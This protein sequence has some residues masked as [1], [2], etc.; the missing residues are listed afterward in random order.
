M[1]SFWTVAASEYALFAAASYQYE[2]CT[3]SFS[4]DQSDL[5]ALAAEFEAEE[6][7]GQ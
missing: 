3:A 1:I 4:L 7:I 2:A 5:S 6:Q